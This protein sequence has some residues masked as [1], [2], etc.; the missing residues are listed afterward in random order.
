MSILKNQRVE[1]IRQLMQSH[2]IEHGD[3]CVI[4]F[5]ELAYDINNTWRAELFVNRENYPYTMIKRWGPGSEVLVLPDHK[6]GDLFRG[7]R[8]AIKDNPYPLE[9][10]KSYYNGAEFI[11]WKNYEEPESTG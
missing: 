1:V 3:K 11:L 9:H 6:L 2:G 7:I 4:S 8:H 5:W 10:R